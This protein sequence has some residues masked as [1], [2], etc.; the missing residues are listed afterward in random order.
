MEI[1]KKRE[2]E[3]NKGIKNRLLILGAV[4]PCLSLL[5]WATALILQLIDAKGIHLSPPLGHSSWPGGSHHALEVI[6]ST[7]SYLTEL[8]TA[9]SEVTLP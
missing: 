4:V 6:N 2:R 8:V 1:E 7:P 5:Y 9:C 3:M